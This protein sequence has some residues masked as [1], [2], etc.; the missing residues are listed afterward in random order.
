MF[1]LTRLRAE[2]VVGGSLKF[3][4]SG[5]AEANNPVNIRQKVTLETV[6]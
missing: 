5:A 2:Q 6:K 4:G 1:P 3:Q